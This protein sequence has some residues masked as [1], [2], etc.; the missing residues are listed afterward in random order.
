MRGLCYFSK[1]WQLT[2]I[3]LDSP[4][5]SFTWMRPFLYFL[6]LSSRPRTSVLVEESALR[7]SILV[8]FPVSN[9]AP[10]VHQGS[11]KMC[12]TTCHSGRIIPQPVDK[13]LL[14]RL[15]VG[16]TFASRF[17]DGAS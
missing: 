7:S 9:A 3:S 5:P 6:P 17:E 4:Q 2:T 11:A 10:T 13:I 15:F 8:P 1:K 16:I 12:L 14:Y